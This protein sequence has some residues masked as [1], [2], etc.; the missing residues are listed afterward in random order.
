MQLEFP[1]GF[2]RHFGREPHLPHLPHSPR[3][4]SLQRTRALRHGLLALAV[5]GALDVQ[6]QQTPAPAPTPARFRTSAPADL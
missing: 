3:A 6:A 1:C 2:E 5:A 4:A